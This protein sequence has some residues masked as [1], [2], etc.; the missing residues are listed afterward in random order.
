MMPR[1]WGEELYLAKLI[2]DLYL[3]F[4]EEP[5]F[6]WI[7]EQERDFVA[8]YFILSYI[9]IEFIANHSGKH[10]GSFMEWN[11]KRV[12]SFEEKKGDE[13]CLKANSFK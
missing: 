2:I 13:L 9:E 1:I 5:T 3:F 11:I 12:K 8:Q 7:I 4:L 10:H 6:L